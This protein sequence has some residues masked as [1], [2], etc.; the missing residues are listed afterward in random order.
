[1]PPADLSARGLRSGALNPPAVVG[2]RADPDLGPA[3]EA[4]TLPVRIGT[5]DGYFLPAIT[6]AL[7]SYFISPFDVDPRM[8][9]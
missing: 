3:S 4:L 2:G 9:Q 6:G 5:R 1:M 7:Y 8:L